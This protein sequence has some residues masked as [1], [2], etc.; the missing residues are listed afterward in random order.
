[1]KLVKLSLLCIVLGIL[2]VISP[3]AHGK[4]L[5]QDTFDDGKIDGKYLFQNHPGKWVEAKGVISQTEPSPQDHCYLVIQ[6]N[7]AE[8]HTVIVKI[9]ID[10][11]A[12]NDL[13]RAGIGV[14]LDKSDGAGYAF[15]IHDNLGNME[16]LNDHIAWKNNDTKP[17][18][19][20]VEVGKWYWM[21]AEITDKKFSG[22]IWPDG[23]NEPTK[24]L[25]ESGFDFGA[26]RAVSGNCGLSGGSNQ[27]TGKTNVSFDDW[28]ICETADEATPKVFAQA[29]ESAGKLSS[30]WGSIKSGY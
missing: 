14:R 1:M 8:P 18:F 13:S 27:G 9:R 5:W 24:W 12:D 30:T 17:P 7:F 22:K 16:F 20:M 15:L 26:V 10:D 11:W 23:E 6:G 25:L 21:K 29:V 28:A 3:I 4:V 19:G 2:L